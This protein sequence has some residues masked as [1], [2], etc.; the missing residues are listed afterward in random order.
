MQTAIFGLAAVYLLAPALLV[1][2]ARYNSL[3]A[4]LGPIV[5]CYIAGLALGMSGLQPDDVKP[6]RVSITEAS[7]GLALP[8]LLFTVDL[9]AWGRIAG[10]ALLSMLLAIIAVAVIASALFFVFDTRGVVEAQQLSGMAVG[11][12]TGGLANMGAIKLALGIPEN[13]YLLFATVDTGVGAV[14]LL[15]ILTLAP[16][17]LG[18][19][20]RPFPRNTASVGE[21]MSKPG[22][23]RRHPGVEG[24]IALAGATLCVGGAVVL[25]P[26]IPIGNAQV[27]TVVL[28][29]SF[30]LIGSLSPALRKNR[31]APAIGMYLLYVFSFSVAAAMDLKAL[32]S[33]EI[34]VLVFVLIATFG[35]FGLHALLA[36][37]V[38]IDRDTFLITSVAAVM[39]PAFVPMVARSLGN[40]AILMSGMA[41]GILGFALGNYLGISLAILLGG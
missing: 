9:R 3:A 33:M 18:R 7:L 28:L 24:L 1:V 23:T 32:Q 6:V 21:Q 17:V 40:P 36:R 11:M 22:R 34:S 35:S 14:Y 13:R 5:L 38:G 26:L 10:S 41:T 25:A 15:F 27:M 29:T 19:L 12:Y 37:L 8:L 16:A 31:F 2:L 30:G 39:S 4:R 20:L